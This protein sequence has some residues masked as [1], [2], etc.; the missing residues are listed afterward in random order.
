M[1]IQRDIESSIKKA[2]SSFQAITLFGSRQVGKTTTI[3]QLFRDSFNYVTL[4][5]ID[6]YELAINN[7]KSFL[8]IHPWPLIIDEVQRA[9]GILNEIKKRIDE[10]R[11]IWLRTNSDRELMYI[12]TGSN[13]F[14][15]QEGISESL[16]GR[17]AIMQLSGMTQMEKRK[18]N[19]SLFNPD[20][21][22]L[23]EKEN[24]TSKKIDNIN[25]IFDLIFLGG[26]PDVV[27]GVTDRDLYYKSYIE[28][29]IEKDVKKLI[30]ASS[31]L[32]FRKFLSLIALRT[33]Q[34][35]NF[36]DLS[37]SVGI[38][39]ETCKRWISI[40]ETSGIIIMLEP[41][42]A[43]L[44]KRVIKSPKLFF[45]DTGICAYLC[46]WPNSE[47]LRNCAMSG[48]FFETYVIS[49]IVK[50]F[51]NY[52]KNPKHYLYYYRDIDKKEVD[53]LYVEND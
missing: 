37:R 34:E 16:A 26:M 8:D 49:E 43:N 44:S 30:S 39:V 25:E 48:A 15:L 17:T 36:A 18:L 12:I 5:D 31:E 41:F 11:D 14:E 7:P 47:M 9:P 21:S 3:K 33:A 4:D 53:L 23:L 35:I 45:M 20:V 10:Q 40:L 50:S 38:D 46:K 51:Y 27:T 32:Q 13:Q 52:S 42:M 24:N 1:Y 22:Y 6:E 28:T 19:G 29:Y 2:A